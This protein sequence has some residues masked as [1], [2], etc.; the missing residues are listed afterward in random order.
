M[1]EDGDE[2]LED[3]DDTISVA[4]DHSD[5]VDNEINSDDQVSAEQKEYDYDEDDGE[6]KDGYDESEEQIS[7][8][9]QLPSTNSINSSTA[10]LEHQ[11]RW[12]EPSDPSNWH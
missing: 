7:V 2:W 4:A 5:Q 6:V 12:L 1:S 10:K 3:G 9:P 8:Q 11:D